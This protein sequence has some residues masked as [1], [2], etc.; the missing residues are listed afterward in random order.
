[1]KKAQGYTLIELLVVI[2]IIG[3]LAGFAYP[4]YISYTLSTNRSDAKAELQKAQLVQSSLHILNPTY[5]ADEGEV[6]LPANH[7]YY[8]FTVISA[9]GTTY[10]MK[11]VAKAGTIQA[12]DDP[13]C[14]TL[15]INQDSAH[16]DGS[17]TNNDEC[18]K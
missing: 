14:T 12:D 2:I 18:W 16:Y 1:M 5:S 8:T 7:D 3:I 15:V 10:S 11:A 9:G 6:G 13:Q 17:G 4:S